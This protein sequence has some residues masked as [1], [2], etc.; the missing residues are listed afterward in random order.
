MKK[1][2]YFHEN[3]S[4]QTV[5]FRITCGCK[6][7]KYSMFVCHSVFFYE[8]ISRVFRCLASHLWSVFISVCILLVIHLTD[9]YLGV[10]SVFY[11]SGRFC[12]SKKHPFSSHYGEEKG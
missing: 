6:A 2:I 11:S 7:G 10:V 9:R 12:S 3:N 8:H 1:N 4:L 5:F